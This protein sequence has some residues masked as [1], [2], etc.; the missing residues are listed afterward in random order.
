MRITFTP[1]YRP[2]TP[3]G[4]LIHRV[5]QAQTPAPPRATAPQQVALWAAG[6]SAAAAVI[7][8][9]LGRPVAAISCGISAAVDLAV[10][11]WSRT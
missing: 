2:Q 3:V 4:N 11:W 8:G 5:Q 1:T 9:V 10:L 6:G 7:L